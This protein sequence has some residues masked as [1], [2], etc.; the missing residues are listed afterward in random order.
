MHKI[1]P[2]MENNSRTAR[3]GECTWLLDEDN[4]LHIHSEGNIDGD[5][6]RECIKVSERLIEAVQGQIDMLI[7]TNKTGKQSSE[8]RQIWKEFSER[9][10]VRR[11]AVHGL[12]PVARVAASF[13]TGIL[14]PDGKNKTKFFKTREEALAWLNEGKQ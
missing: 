14:S 13:I 5:F 1:K 2:C 4:V 9:P 10:I 8:A 11:V 6:A 7:D 12:H 3:L